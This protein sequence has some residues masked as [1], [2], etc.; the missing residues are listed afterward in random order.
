MEGRVNKEGSLLKYDGFLIPFKCFCIEVVKATIF[1]T[2][3]T[4]AFGYL[5][6]SVVFWFK[7]FHTMFV[8]FSYEFHNFFPCDILNI[9]I[10]PV[11]KCILINAFSYSSCQFIAY[12]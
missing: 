11:H 5:Q 10:A 3:M 12:Q 9:I 2:K 6:T 1:Y 8:S 7:L 4:L